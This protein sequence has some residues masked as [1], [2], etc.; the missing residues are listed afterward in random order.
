[1][2]ETAEAIRAQ[3]TRRI[4][5]LYER[6][7]EGLPQVES[8]RKWAARH[9]IDPAKY[10]AW[11]NGTQPDYEGLVVLQ[12]KFAIPWQWFLVG[13][14]GAVEIRRTSVARKKRDEAIRR[15]RETAIGNAHLHQKTP[16][17]RRDVG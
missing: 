17:R 12:E 13:D 6:E 15:Q 9:G 1:M 8:Q 4:R 11:W 5:S 14:E 2:P 7:T 3:I 16:A 10:N